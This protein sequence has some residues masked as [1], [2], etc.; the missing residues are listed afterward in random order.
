MVLEGG[1]M[2][3]SLRMGYEDLDFGVVELPAHRTRANLAFTV[4]FVIP[5][6]TRNPEGAWQLMKY[7]AGRDG[8]QA[9]TS[10]GM[11][12]PSRRSVPGKTVDGPNAAHWQALAAGVEYARPW[13][14][15]YR[16]TKV[17]DRS[18][19]NLEAVFLD[20]MEIDDALSDMVEYGERVLSHTRRRD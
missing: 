1:W 3:P 2:I 7:L 8:M 16:F 6:S 19:V 15:T 11:A 12:L 20:R 10:L 9:W 13:Q 14:F 5:R 18:N 4:A 17:L